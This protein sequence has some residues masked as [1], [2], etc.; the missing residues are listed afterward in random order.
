MKFPHKK[1]DLHNFGCDRIF[2]ISDPDNIERRQSFI[3]DWKY[4]DGFDYEFITSVNHKNGDFDIDKLLRSGEMSGEWHDLEQGKGN[5]PGLT[6]NMIGIGLAHKKCWELANS[7][8]GRKFLILEDDARPNDKLI[9]YI[10]DGTYKLLIEKLHKQYCDIFWIGRTTTQ[11]VGDPLDNLFQIPKSHIG[12]SAHSYIVDKWCL[13]NL[14]KNYKLQMPVD[15]FIE[16][17]GPNML[18]VLTNVYS[19]YFSLIEQK[20]HLIG[21]WLQTDSTDPDFIFSTTSQVNTLIEEPLEHPWRYTSQLMREHCN[22]NIEIYNRYGYKW[23][24]TTLK[25]RYKLL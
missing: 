6:E 21:K 22:D 24:R 9:D 17:M 15:L 7:E 19:P 4:F 10:Y 8:S 16:Y 11:I 3:D 13:H 20:G 5:Q 23:T 2:V 14:I 25:E 12:V 1:I 18:G